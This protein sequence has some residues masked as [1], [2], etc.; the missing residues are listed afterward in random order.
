M[1]W[2]G[3]WSNCRGAPTVRCTASC[4]MKQDKHV[5]LALV[6]K[7]DS[8]QR[9]K[10]QA[11]AKAVKTNGSQKLKQLMVANARKALGQHMRGG[12]RPPFTAMCW[13]ITFWVWPPSVVQLQW[14]LAFV[15]FVCF[16]F[17]NPIRFEV[18]HS[19]YDVIVARRDSCSNQMVRCCGNAIHHHH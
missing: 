10:K 1:L 11:G 18:N 14:L 13:P 4:T 9:L 16:S 7:T 8:G 19:C 6:P 2:F 3:T 12:L 17:G 5:C 15:P